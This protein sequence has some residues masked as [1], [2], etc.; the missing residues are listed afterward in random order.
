MEIFIAYS[1]LDGEFLVRGNLAAV[2]FAYPQRQQFTNACAKK[3][4][5]LRV[6]GAFFTSI[7]AANHT[8]IGFGRTTEPRL[9]AASIGAAVAN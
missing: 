7:D 9:E 3:R 8:R 1:R 5:I 4:S 6:S 2:F